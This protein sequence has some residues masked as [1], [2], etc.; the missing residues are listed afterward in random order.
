M[1]M[2][3]INIGWPCSTQAYFWSSFQSQKCAS[4][5]HCSDWLPLL[6]RACFGISQLKHIS[7]PWLALV[8]W[9]FS[10]EIKEGFWFRFLFFPW[11][12]SLWGMKNRIQI[13][14]WLS[15]KHKCLIIFDVWHPSPFIN[16][17]KLE[18]C[19]LTAF[20]LDLIAIIS[21]PQQYKS[22]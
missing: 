5:F 21:N 6:C 8:F 4:T 19:L 15:L 14:C 17:L 12:T 18:W 11:P 13:S 10:T 22:V 3:V 20:P 2:D 7:L 16:F 1:S 9:P